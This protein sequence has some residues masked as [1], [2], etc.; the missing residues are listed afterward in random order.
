MSERFEI[1]QII[2]SAFYPIAMD[3]I[4]TCRPSALAPCNVA[5]KKASSTVICNFITANVII[6]DMDWI[7]QLPGLKSVANAIWIFASRNFLYGA[8][9]FFPK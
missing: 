5:A 3:P 2:R 9:D 6:N 7:W 1:S 4:S 8:Y